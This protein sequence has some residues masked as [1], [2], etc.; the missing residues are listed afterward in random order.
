MTP[1]RND[2]SL[3]ISG[4]DLERGRKFAHLFSESLHLKTVSE[5][6]GETLRYHKYCKMERI[7]F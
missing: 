1:F 7:I 5:I 4:S 2:S 6:F 3:L